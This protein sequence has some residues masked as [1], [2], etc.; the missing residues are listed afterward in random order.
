MY[1]PVPPCTNLFLKQVVLLPL[2]SFTIK[3]SDP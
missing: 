1:V 3:K 2:G